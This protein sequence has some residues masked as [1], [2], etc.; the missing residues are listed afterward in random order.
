MARSVLR[1]L[2]SPVTQIVVAP[3]VTPT[4]ASLLRFGF[5][6]RPTVLV[7]TFS[8]SLDPTLAQDLANYRLV[9]RV[10]LT[11]CAKSVSSDPRTNTVTLRPR[12][13]IDLH[14]AVRVTVIGTGPGGIR[15][16]TSPWTAQ[17]RTLRVPISSQ[18]WISEISWWSPPR[19]HEGSCT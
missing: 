8:E 12:E 3:K 13:K 18:S 10:N 7:L 1:A 11:D 14:Y 16:T 5:H 19:K 15:S 2:S 6:M 17:A 9:G 4:A